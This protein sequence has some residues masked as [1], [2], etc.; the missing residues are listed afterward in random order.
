MLFPSKDEGLKKKGGKDK[1]GEKITAEGETR[2]IIFLKMY[3]MLL[4]LHRGFILH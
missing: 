1:D 4:N 3:V 2:D